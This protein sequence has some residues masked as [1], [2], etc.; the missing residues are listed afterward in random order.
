MCGFVYSISQAPL[1]AKAIV[2]SFRMWS[3][4]Q[5]FRFSRQ[6]INVVVIALHVFIAPAL[7]SDAVLRDLHLDEDDHSR[8]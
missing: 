7:E 4:K 2:N 3:A 6:P 5:A 8:R 1:A